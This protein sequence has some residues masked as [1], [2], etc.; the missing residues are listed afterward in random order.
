M[1]AV[2]ITLTQGRHPFRSAITAMVV[3]ISVHAGTYRMFQR[4]PF[5]EVPGGAIS[6]SIARVVPNAYSCN[7]HT[8][9]PLVCVKGEFAQ[10]TS[11]Q[12]LLLLFNKLCM[13]LFRISKTAT[14]GLCVQLKRETPQK[15]ASAAFVQ[16]IDGTLV[17]GKTRDF[18]RGP[19]KRD[20]WARNPQYRKFEF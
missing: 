11:H 1:R 14:Y 13:L 3:H 20:C 19:R 10:C 17:Q 12:Q 7:T 6:A 4:C 16:Q 18:T 5:S 15:L 9:K 8:Q 2:M